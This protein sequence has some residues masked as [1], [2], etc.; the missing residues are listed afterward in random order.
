VVEGEVSVLDEEGRNGVVDMRSDWEHVTWQN[1]L[2]HLRE[3]E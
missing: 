1:P 2:L 3:I